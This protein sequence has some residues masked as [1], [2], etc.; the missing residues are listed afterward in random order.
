MYFLSLLFCKS[1]TERHAELKSWLYVALAAMAFVIVGAG[2]E[3]IILEIAFVL[4]L[5]LRHGAAIAAKAVRKSINVITA[6]GLMA[7][8]EGRLVQRCAAGIGH[9]TDVTAR[10]RTL[11]SRQASFSLLGLP[12]PGL[13]ARLLPQPGSIARL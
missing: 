12:H 9:V 13:T 4:A 10:R 3:L 6:I 2:A 8:A 5:C 1:A 7:R 11:E